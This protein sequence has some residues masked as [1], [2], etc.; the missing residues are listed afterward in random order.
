MN[1]GAFSQ[2]LQEFRC[3]LHSSPDGVPPVQRQYKLLMRL[4]HPHH[5]A[6]TQIVIRE[7]QTQPLLACSCTAPKTASERVQQC[8]SR[9]SWTGKPSRC[10][11]WISWK[12]AV[13]GNLSH[14]VHTAWTSLLLERHEANCK[15]IYFIHVTTVHLNKVFMMQ[16]LH[17][18]S[19][20]SLH[21]T[22]LTL[23]KYRL[24]CVKQVFRS[25]FSSQR[26]FIL[27]EVLLTSSGI[28]L[29]CI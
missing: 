12:F 23:R 22:H 2:A 20:A 14:V 1:G 5:P 13:E 4:Y 9:H 3:D 15:A 19:Y 21:V 29:E 18:R 6:S 17:T 8:A 28:R 7:G 11:C 26:T 24:I 16:D 10:T 25:C 27:G